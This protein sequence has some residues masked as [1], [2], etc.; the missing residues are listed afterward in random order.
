MKTKDLRNMTDS[1]LNLKLQEC[2]KRLLNFRSEIKVGRLQKPHEINICRRDI[3][4]MQTVL[5]ERKK[6]VA[7]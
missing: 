3:A 2:Y 7:K 1:E 6:E 5:N 4:K